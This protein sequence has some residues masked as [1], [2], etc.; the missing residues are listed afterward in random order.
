MNA[1]TAGA[2]GYTLFTTRDYYGE[3]PTKGYFIAR[4]IVALGGSRG[5]NCIFSRFKSY[6]K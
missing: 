6:Y 3:Y 4:M 1:N 2:G 5:R